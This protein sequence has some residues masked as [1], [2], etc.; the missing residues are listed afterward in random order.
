MIFVDPLQSDVQQQLST[1]LNLLSKVVWPALATLVP[2]A[3]TALFKIAQDH[4]RKRLGAQLT[5]RIAS[6][7]KCISELPEFPLAGGTGVTPRTALTAELNSAVN[8]LTALQ[9]RVG[10]HLPGMTTMTTRLRAAFLLFRPKGFLAFTL[11]TL[12]YLYSFGL[13]FC[14]IAVMADRSSPFISTASAGAFFSDL[15]AFIF[16]FGILGVPPLVIRYFAARIHRRQCLESHPDGG[17]TATPPV[18][19][20]ASASGPGI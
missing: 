12:F 11:H 16:I 15:L 10:R 14:L 4:S 8:E 19:A 17:T 6:L 3:I 2:A 13:I 20:S 7:A 18:A 1:K 5:D 9:N